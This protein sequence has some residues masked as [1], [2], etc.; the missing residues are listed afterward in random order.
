M[1]D[2]S[3]ESWSTVERDDISVRLDPERIKSKVQWTGAVGRRGELDDLAEEYG[4]PSR[5]AFLRCMIRMGMNSLVENDP[6]ET[7]Q[8]SKTQD[9]TAVTIRDLIPEGEENAVDMT[10]EF[11]DE[12]LRDQMLDIVEQDPNIERSGYKIHR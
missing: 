9:D 11:W 12:I 3:N 5:S 10:D 4:F 1:T 7:N 2:S 6:V 8:S